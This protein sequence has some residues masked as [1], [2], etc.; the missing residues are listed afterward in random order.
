MDRE[1]LGIGNTTQADDSEGGGLGGMREKLKGS[2][3]CNIK[4]VRNGKRCSWRDRQR[5]H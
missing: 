5:T 3:D 1:K 4:S 2:D